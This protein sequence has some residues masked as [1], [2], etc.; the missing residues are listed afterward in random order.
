MDYILIILAIV[1]AIVGL[2]GAFLPVLPGTPLSLFALLL[3]YMCDFV[4]SDSNT[5]ILSTVFAVVITLLDYI[6]PVWFAKIGGGTKFG[7]NGAAI[8]FFVGLFCGP[9]GIVI[10]SFL[11]AFLGELAAKTPLRDA[12]KIALYSFLSFILTTGIKIIYGIVMLV[13]VLKNCL[14]L[15]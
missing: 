1:S 6:A 11:G 10:G 8:G 9:S 15:F 2:A 12:V 13:I 5:L 3:L 14:T 7:I 4:P